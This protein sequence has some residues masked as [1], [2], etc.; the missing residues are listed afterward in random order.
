MPPPPK[1]GGFALLTA[2]WRKAPPSGELL[3]A[4]KRRGFTPRETPPVISLCSM[5]DSPFCRCATS[6][7]APGEVIFGDGAFGMAAKFLAKVQNVRARQRLPPRGSWQNRQVLT[8]GVKHPLSHAKSTAS[9]YGKR[10]FFQPFSA[11]L[12]K[13]RCSFS[14]SY[15]WGP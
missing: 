14:S 10:C 9:L 2:R 4:A 15:W 13:T 3:S 7:P 1:G 12:W 8:E 6:S 11:R 5:P